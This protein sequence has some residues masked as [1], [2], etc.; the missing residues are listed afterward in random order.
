MPFQDHHPANH[1]AV[2]PNCL[3]VIDLTEDPEAAKVVCLKCGYRS[4]FRK[5]VLVD[6]IEATKPA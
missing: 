5:A 6:V 1:D 3:S 2:C 4:T